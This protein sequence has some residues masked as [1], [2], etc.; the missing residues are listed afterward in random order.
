MNSTAP[1]FRF[2]PIS[3]DFL[4]DP[5]PLYRE[6]QDCSPVVYHE[7]SDQYLIT[8][9]RDVAKA[10]GDAETFRSD[11]ERIDA[12]FGGRT[13]Q[14]V[15]DRK[16]HGKLKGIWARDF[17]PR[18]LEAQREMIT[19]V[20]DES[21]PSFVE[22]VRAGE[23]V[24]A[25]EA[26]TRAIPT[27]V[28]AKMM[29]I[30]PEDYRKFSGWSDDMGR[31]LDSMHDP[32]PRGAEITRQAVQATS[33]LNQYV[34][35]E[36]GPRRNKPGD[37]LIS[38]MVTHPDAE[39]LSENDVVA[40]NTQLVFAGNETTTKLMSHILNALAL[41]PEQRRS[42]VEDRSLIPQAIE[43]IHRWVTVAQTGLRLVRD[44]QSAVIGGVEI[45]AGSKVQTLRAAANRDPDR[46]EN[47]DVLDIFREPKQHLGFGFGMHSCLGLNLARLE[48]E[49]WLDRLL[50]VLPEWDVDTVEWN[51]SWAVRGP[52]VLKIV[53]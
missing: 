5:Y 44:D 52:A 34:R 26:M 35:G 12:L 22:R 47:P 50:D 15:D 25:V 6:M 31:L 28:I 40:S 14:A 43:E 51:P 32:T 36:L 24:D 16:L 37:D 17:W 23:A 53:A 11:P 45:P 18:T 41:H 27:M 13:M 7:D 3:P 8:R 2:D 1:V 4:A 42:L 33:E 39:Q 19:E 10:L 46:W 9:W 49:V 48:V 30:S 20:V 38:K 21:L 29:G